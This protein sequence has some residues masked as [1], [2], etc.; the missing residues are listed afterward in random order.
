MGSVRRPDP[1]HTPDPT[2]LQPWLQ[3]SLKEQ[4]AL[5][6]SGLVAGAILSGLWARSIRAR[7]GTHHAPP[8]PTTPHHTPPRSTRLATRAG[9][10]R[11]GDRAARA[12]QYRP[13]GLLRRSGGRRRGAVGVA[14][15]GEQL[16]HCAPGAVVGAAAAGV[17]RELRDA[18][19]VLPSTCS[20][21]L[22]AC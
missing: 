5:E 17:Q 10:R 12:A 3:L 16:V 19:R 7:L 15:F 20:L 8:R 1:L 22:A 4:T 6:P 18:V 13:R 2:L 9:G 14:A 21:L 11:R